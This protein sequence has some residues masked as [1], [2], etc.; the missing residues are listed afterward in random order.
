MD[1][2]REHQFN[3]SSL[4]RTSFDLADAPALY[5]GELILLHFTSFRRLTL[6]VV[7]EYKASCKVRLGLPCSIWMSFRQRVNT[8]RLRT[9]QARLIK[10]KQ[11]A[12]IMSGNSGGGGLLLQKGLGSSWGGG[13]TSSV[14]LWPRGLPKGYLPTGCSA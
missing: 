9:E 2:R 12:R 11:D 8:V 5:L 4:P 1:K 3:L 6:E 14:R 7:S 13:S 10:Q